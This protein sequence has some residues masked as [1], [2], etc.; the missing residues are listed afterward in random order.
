MPASIQLHVWGDF[1]CFTRPEMKAERVSYDIITPS[2]ARGIFEAIYWKPQITWTIE[3]INLLKPIRFTSIRRN[4]VGK[5]APSP[6]KKV[7]TGEKQPSP[8]LIEDERQQRASLVLRDVAYLI[9][10]SVRIHDTR[11][12]RGGPK[13]PTNHIA[14]KHLDIFKRRARKGQYFHH[15]YLGTREFPASFALIEDPSD[16][17]ASQLSPAEQNRDFGFMLHDIEFDQDPKSKKVRSTTPR[18]FRAEMT[19]GAVIVPPFRN[20]IA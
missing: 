7:I 12:E 9:E 19:N 6:D 18:F 17:P 5:K 16:T 14:G 11:M 13:V 10:A 4:E 15:P 3:K 1:A 20:S 8:I 2:A